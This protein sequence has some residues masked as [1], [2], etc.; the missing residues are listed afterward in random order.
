MNNKESHWPSPAKLNLFLHIIGQRES[1]GETNN[2]YHNLQSV[3]QL[4][5]YGDT[6][7]IKLLSNNN[8]EFECNLPE[9]SDNNNLVISAAHQLQQYG[10]KH[11]GKKT[12]GAKIFLN[13]VLPV[14]GGV[15]GG[16]SNCATALIA[17]N[18]LWKL[19]ISIEKLAE[20]G[21][22]LGADVPIFIKG[23]SAFV[24]G[25][26]EIITPFQLPKAWY[27]VIQPTCH[28]ST[29]KIFSNPLLTRNT[30]AIRIR[31][32]DTLEL[33]FKGLN[34]LQPI[35]CNDYPMVKK[36]LDWLKQFNQ[37]ARMT[38]SG[39]CVFAVFDNER[40]VRKIAS[41]CEWSHFVTFGVNTSPLHIKLQSLTQ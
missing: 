2:G 41:R 3:F 24:E 40:E 34:T 25:V 14:G 9:L 7:D 36:A 29:S 19:N 30:K 15:G 16:S 10:L 26:G 31:D 8:I 12:L 5:D 28:V 18:H 27:L 38:G 23:K 21:L 11:Q 13:K 37:D 1:V 17:L 4:L 35:V 22:D 6:L 33:P 20:I 32:L 39:S